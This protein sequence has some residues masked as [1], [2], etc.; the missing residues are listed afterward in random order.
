MVQPFCST[1]YISLTRYH[2]IIDRRHGMINSL[3]TSTH[4][5][6]WES[7]LRPVDLE[8]NPLSP[9]SGEGYVVFNATP[10]P[11]LLNKICLNQPL[12]TQP[13]AHMTETCFSMLFVGQE[14]ISSLVITHHKHTLHGFICNNRLDDIFTSNDPVTLNSSKL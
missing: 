9:L 6:W 7:N 4:D 1:R 14:C 11:F 2:C 3:D 10:N 12:S 13:Q 5:Q 8:F